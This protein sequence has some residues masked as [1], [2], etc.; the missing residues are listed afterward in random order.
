MVLE[1]HLEFT[2]FL[3]D[4]GFSKPNLVPKT[5]SWGL[6]AEK[7]LALQTQK[8]EESSSRPLTYFLPYLLITALGIY[9]DRLP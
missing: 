7:T 1:R 6:C 5:V 4:S 8:D 3:I 2:G 9:Y